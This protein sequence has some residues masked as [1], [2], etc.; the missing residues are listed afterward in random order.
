MPT[1]QRPGLNALCF[2]SRQWVGQVVLWPMTFYWREEVDLWHMVWYS[3]GIV[4]RRERKS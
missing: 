2:S 4:G 3:V 1:A